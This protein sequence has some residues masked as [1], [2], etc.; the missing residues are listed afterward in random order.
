MSRTRGAL[1]AVALVSL[2]GVPC[3]AA[4]GRTGSCRPGPRR[5]PRLGLHPSESARHASRRRRR[6][7]PTTTSASRFPGRARRSRAAS[8]ERPRR[9]WTGIPR[10]AEGAR[11]TSCDFGKEGVRQCTLCHL[12]DGSGRPENAPVSSLNPVYFMQ[13]MQDYRN[14][15]RR[16]A[17][18]R[19]ANTNTMIGFAKATTPEEDR[20][21]AEFFAH[22]A[23]PAAAQGRGVEDG[24]ESPTAGR[25]AH[26]HSGWRGGGM[27]PIKAD[28]IVE[29]PDDNLRAEARDT[30]MSFTAYVPPGTLNRGKQAA[31]KYQC[32]TCHGA[33]ME[34]IG[35][36]PRTRRPVAQLHDATAVRHEAGRP[37]RAV[38]RADEASRQRDDGAGNAGCLSLRVV[39]PPTA[40]PHGRLRRAPR[41]DFRS[42]RLP[43]AFRS[44]R[45][46]VR[47]TRA[48]RHA[49]PPLSGGLRTLVDTGGRPNRTWWVGRTASGRSLAAKWRNA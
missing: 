19:K 45:R 32:A 7:R 6:C 28:E 44:S 26:G 13:Q 14:G 1:L 48:E 4:A 24:P 10:I 18:P 47:E 23:V 16:S 37:T 31:A 34:G 42:G 2:R 43:H 29:V 49:H 17:D 8:F 9:R 22:A 46:A 11:P 33:N 30:R 41:A 35:P 38:G 20:A 12:P 5:S 36:V 25:D 27:V 15:L 39:V 3:R 40:Q 21:A